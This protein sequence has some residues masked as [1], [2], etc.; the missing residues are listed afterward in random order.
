LN[1]LQATTNGKGNTV[2]VSELSPRGTLVFATYLGG[3]APA[4]SEASSS[5]A[6]DTGGNIYVAGWTAS[7]DFPVKNACQANLSTSSGDAFVTK[8][9][10]GGSALVYST[11]LGGA[12][13][14]GQSAGGVAA[15]A[16]GC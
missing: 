5:I 11:F 14:I 1:P 9:E 13:N 10:P 6:V 8:L 15:D 7:P 16:L 3:M 2:F 4:D 12:G